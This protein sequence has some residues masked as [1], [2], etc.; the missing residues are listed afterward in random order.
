MPRLHIMWG[1]AFLRPSNDFMDSYIFCLGQKL[2]KK[3][4][5]H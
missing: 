5:I 3:S 4:E 2:E 1:R